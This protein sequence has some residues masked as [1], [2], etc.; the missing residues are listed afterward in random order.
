[1]YYIYPVEVAWYIHYAEPPPTEAE[2]KIAIGNPRQVKRKG[3]EVIFDIYYI[4]VYKNRNP[5][6]LRLILFLTFAIKIAN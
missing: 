6:G 5:E 1:M 2:N 3:G 4:W